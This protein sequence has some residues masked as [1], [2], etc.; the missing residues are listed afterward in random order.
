[1]HVE[2]PYEQVVHPYEHVVHA[3][4]VW[5]GA[6]AAGWYTVVGA[7]ETAYRCIGA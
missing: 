7:Y 6:S 2:H 5:T 3:G 4:A 1:V